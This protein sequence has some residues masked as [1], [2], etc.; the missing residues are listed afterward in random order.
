MRQPTPARNRDQDIPT[1]SGEEMGDR[2]PLMPRPGPGR[3]ERNAPLPEEETYERDRSREPPGDKPRGHEAGGRALRGVANAIKHTL[4]QTDIGARW[5]GDEFVIIAPNTA[6]TAAHRL[7]ER[8]LLDMKKLTTPGDATP[9]ASVGLAILDPTQIYWQV[10][11]RR[12]SP[13]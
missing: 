1:K 6:R 8:L 2:E 10:I 13:A 4:R 12:R 9:S 11:Q 5:G 7:G 3:E